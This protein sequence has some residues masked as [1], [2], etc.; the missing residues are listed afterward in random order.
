MKPIFHG[1]PSLPWGKFAEPRSSAPGTFA[2]RLVVGGIALASALVGARPAEAEI[3]NGQITQTPASP[4]VPPPGPIRGY[5]RTRMTAPSSTF[6]A[7]GRVLAVFLR[8]RESLP[9]ESRPPLEMRLSGLTLAPSVASCEVDGK[10][11]LHNDDLEPATFMVAGKPLGVVKPG[12]SVAYECTAGTRGEEL[13][14]VEV[15]EWPRVKGGIY[16]G[17]VGA[18]A[19]VGL[20]GRF[21]L[22]AS[23]GTYVLRVI[24]EDGVLTERDVVVDGRTVDVGTIDLADAAGRN[25]D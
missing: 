9:L 19:P 2:R 18:A 7:R 13:R 23:R 25:G 8:V 1:I 17:E 20:D 24:G 15:L 12:D 16:V 4:T 14:T 5:V 21:S 6:F 3:V 10:V 11:V 22:V